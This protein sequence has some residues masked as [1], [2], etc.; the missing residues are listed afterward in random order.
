MDN[1][2]L[3]SFDVGIINL[4][5]CILTK[6]K[7]DE[8]NELQWDIIEW[9]IIDLTNKSLQNCNCGKKAYYMHN[10]NNNLNYYCKTHSKNVELPVSLF[11]DTYI[12]DININNICMYKNK[13]TCTKNACYT[14]TNNSYYCTIHA[15]QKYKQTIINSTIKP[16]KQTTVYNFND[17]TLKLIQELDKRKHFLRANYV[18]I[19]NQPSFKNP[20]MKSISTLLYN[21]FMIRGITDKIINNSQLI[22]VKFISPS[23]KLKL[24]N[25]TDKEALNESKKSANKSYKLSKALSIKYC[26]NLINHLPVM[27]LFFNKSKKKDDLA[28]CFLQ[29]IYYYNNR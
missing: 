13:I 18:L 23:N 22:D 25:D 29:A 24:I 8:T 2:I 21:Y 20:K 11:E 14:D 26:D 9:D 27:K 16:I 4:S 1:P 19:E 10:I 6:K 15:K 12:K 28:D 5:Y 7:C 3:L 17:N